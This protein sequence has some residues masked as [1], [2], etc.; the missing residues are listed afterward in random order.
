M[1]IGLP[2]TFAGPTRPSGPPQNGLR[3]PVAVSY[4]RIVTWISEFAAT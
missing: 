2:F 3:K 4:C 1:G